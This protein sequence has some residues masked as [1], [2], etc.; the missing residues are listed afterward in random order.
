MKKILILIIFTFVFASTAN[1]GFLEDFFRGVQ[2][3]QQADRDSETTIAGLKEA[4]SIGTNNAVLSVSK[5]DG[6]F[7][8]EA[9]KILLPKNIQNIANILSKIGYQKEVDEFILSMNRA[10]E[11]AAPKAK[12]IFI[13]AIRE[14]T[15][16]DALKILNGGDTAATEYFK[17]KNF[18]SFTNPL[19]Q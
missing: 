5:I 12:D 8:N 13:M 16:E 18:I 4:L 1:A 3:P 17:S 10:A 7:K 11:K 19:N 14:M 2:L 9:I 15:I 6:Y